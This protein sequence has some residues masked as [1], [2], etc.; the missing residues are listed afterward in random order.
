MTQYKFHQ[1]DVFSKQTLKGNPLAVVHHA[2]GLATSTM[3]DFAS[4]TNLSETTFL[5]QPEHPQADYKVR[6][7]TPGK[8]L[9]FAGHPTLGSCYAWLAN[10]GKPK[11]PDFIFQE[12][13]IGLVKIRQAG[14]KLAFAAPALLK[15]GELDEAMLVQIAAGLGLRRQDILLHQWVDNGPGW[16]VVMLESAEKVRAIQPNTTYL[17]QFKLGVIGPC[18]EDSDVDYEVR[19]FVLPYGVTEDPVTGSLNA[20]IAQWLIGAGLSKPHYVAAQG[21]ALRRAGRVY[22]DQEGDD[23]WVGG[24]VAICIEGQVAI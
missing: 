2:D 21:T 13:G 17:A 20:G 5:L 7:F 18:M 8:E 19:A 14:S 9:P 23:I 6:I 3:A 4:W 1:L 15:T 10:G 12:C 11:N 22:I 16:C 24:E